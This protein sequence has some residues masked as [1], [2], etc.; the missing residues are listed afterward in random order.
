MKHSIFPRYKFIHNN[1]K[2]YNP[3]SSFK[4]KLE[5]FE[6][7]IWAIYIFHYNFP[8]IRLAKYSENADQV[9][10]SQIY[11]NRDKETVSSLS[12]EKTVST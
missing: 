3:F 8:K 12:R 9:V 5:H 1:I 6:G 2:L 10:Q 11:L 7:A 4:F